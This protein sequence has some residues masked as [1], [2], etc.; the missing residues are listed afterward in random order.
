MKVG[1]AFQPR[2]GRGMP[3]KLL[4]GSGSSRARVHL[5][6]AQHISWVFWRERL[7]GIIHVVLRSLD[8]A[9]IQKPVKQDRVS[10]QCKQKR[11]SL[12]RL[13]RMAGFKHLHRSRE[14][15]C[16]ILCFGGGAFPVAI[17]EARNVIAEI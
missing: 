4:Q 15:C 3:E 16:G 17:E 5:G 8:G 11:T 12:L 2:F 9:T 13:Y 7:P 1:A 6:S 10:V 14:A